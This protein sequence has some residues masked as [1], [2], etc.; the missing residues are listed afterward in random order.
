MWNQFYHKMTFMWYLYYSLLYQITLKI[1]EDDISNY[2]P[3]VIFRGTQSVY[4]SSF[5]ASGEEIILITLYC[6]Y[7]KIKIIL[8]SRILGK[9]K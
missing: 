4:E 8:F 2:S 6:I 9:P 7:I 1:M 5:V 3:T